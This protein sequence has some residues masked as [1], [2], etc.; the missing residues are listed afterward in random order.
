MEIDEGVDT[1]GQTIDLVSEFT[2]APLVNVVDGTLSGRDNASSKRLDAPAFTVEGDADY[3][4]AYGIK[5]NMVAYTVNYQDASGNSLAE[6]DMKNGC[7]T[8]TWERDPGTVFQNNV[9]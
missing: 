6:V 4:V 5:G 7:V 2:L 3:V 9:F 8:D 1:V